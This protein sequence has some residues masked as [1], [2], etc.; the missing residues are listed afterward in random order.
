MNETVILKWFVR[1]KLLL[2]VAFCSMFCVHWARLLS[3][4]VDTGWWMV[5]LF[6]FIWLQQ[7]TFWNQN[8]SCKKNQN[9]KCCTSGATDGVRC[10]AGVT[11]RSNLR[12]Y[13]YPLFVFSWFAHVRLYCLINESSSRPFPAAWAPANFSPVALHHTN[14]LSAKRWRFTACWLWINT[15]LKVKWSIWFDLT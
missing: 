9:F 8:Y 2:S 11:Q 6:V 1:E 13:Y 12:C 10:A 5:L 7:S 14:H 4:P 15:P 3:L